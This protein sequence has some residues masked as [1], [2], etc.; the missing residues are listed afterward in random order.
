MSFCIKKDN[1]SDKDIAEAVA[2][3]R[4]ELN[5]GFLSSLGDGA[6]NLLFSFAAHNSN[7]VFMTAEDETSGKTVAFLLGTNNISLFYK[8]FLREKSLKAFFVLFTKLISFSRIKK[9]FETLF[10]PSKKEHQDFPDAELLDIAVLQEYQGKGIAKK[11]F[12]ELVDEFNAKNISEF[13][14]TTGEQL[15]GAHKFYEKLGAEKVAEIEVHQGQKTFVYIYNLK[16]KE[17]KAS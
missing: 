14:I 4:K 9:I 12:M 11:L 7:A 16:E 15:L 13:K 3:H 5:Q 2:I 6:L 17:G 10:Y 1:F 8:D